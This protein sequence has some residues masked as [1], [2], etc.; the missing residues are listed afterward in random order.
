M[1]DNWKRGGMKW[2]KVFLQRIPL[3]VRIL[4][5][6]KKNNCGIKIAETGI[7]YLFWFLLSSLE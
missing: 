4:K 5:R 1:E 2:I 6:V 3:K 7:S